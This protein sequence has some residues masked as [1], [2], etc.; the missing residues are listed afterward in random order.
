M[1]DKKTNELLKI[2]D[3]QKNNLHYT[4][5]NCTIKQKTLV[6]QAFYN[7]TLRFGASMS[8]HLINS[9]RGYNILSQLFQEYVRLLEA[10]MPFA[11][12]K[13]KEL[14]EIDSIFHPLFNPFYGVS[15][16][17]T[18][19]DKLG[20]IHNNTNELYIGNRTGHCCRPYYIGKLLDIFDVKTKQSVMCSV[21][22]YTFL[23]IRTSLSPDT[24]VI[25]KHLRIPAHY[26]MGILSHINRIKK[27]ISEEA[28]KL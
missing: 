9:K 19:T 2:I 7:L 18:I 16:F 25:V 4:S 28:R 13:D 10:S 26:Q 5:V 23:L 15:E 22:D 24:E 11:Y 1:L 14:I 21:K 27:N 6:Y 3:N 20:V 17:S 8:E 12:K